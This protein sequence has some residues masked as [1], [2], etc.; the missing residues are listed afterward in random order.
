M[1]LPNAIGYSANQSVAST[2]ETNDLQSIFDKTV[3]QLIPQNTNIFKDGKIM[4]SINTL[5]DKTVKKKRKSW[6]TVQASG[7]LLAF[8]QKKGIEAPSSNT[9]TKKEDVVLEKD[10]HIAHKERNNLFTAKINGFEIFIEGENVIAKLTKNCVGVETIKRT[11]ISDGFVR[12]DKK[13]KI[14]EKI[15]SPELYNLIL[16]LYEGELEVV[17]GKINEF[18]PKESVIING[19]AVPQATDFL[20]DKEVYVKMDTYIPLRNIVVCGTSNVTITPKKGDVIKQPIGTFLS[21]ILN[22]DLKLE[23]LEDGFGD[24]Q[25]L[26]IEKDN[27]LSIYFA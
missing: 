17:L 5:L 22:G 19:N 13:G 1:A 27:V 25:I 14:V 26:F 12:V 2:Q 21:S 3:K 16:P 20:Y 15:D 10:F 8:L 11:Q 18:K 23:T 9:F 24:K 4:L 7:D 6:E